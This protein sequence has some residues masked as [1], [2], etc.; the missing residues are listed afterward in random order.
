MGAAVIAG[1]GTGI[2][3]DFHAIDRFLEIADVQEPDV[4]VYEIY[5]QE[6][7]LFD[8]CYQA[9]EPLFGRMN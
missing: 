8:A 3:Q 9:L 4:S 5:R 7:E 1:V 2:Y 6:K